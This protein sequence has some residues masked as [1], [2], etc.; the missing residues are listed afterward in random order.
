MSPIT[1][2]K[3][4]SRSLFD[5]AMTEEPSLKKT[6]S[7]LSRASLRGSKGSFAAYG[8]HFLELHRA[9][10]QWIQRCCSGH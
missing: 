1:F 5:R 8:K 2:Q 4:L 9:S 7:E 3:K 6:A 10:A